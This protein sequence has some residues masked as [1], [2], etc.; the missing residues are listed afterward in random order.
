SLIARSIRCRRPLNSSAISGPSQALSAPVCSLGWP[1]WC[2]WETARISASS[3]NDNVTR[4]GVTDESFIQSS[5]LRHHGRRD[6]PQPF[7]ELAL[8]ARHPLREGC[9]H[10]GERR[11]GRVLGGQNGPL[12]KRQASRQA[13]KL[14]SRCVV[15]L[16]QYPARRPFF[17]R[18]P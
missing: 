16:G 17:H 15:G 7:P 5:G 14:G 3:T 13:S 1:T 12:A 9:E 6:S 2:W 18:Q 11:P 4:K 8:R 10:R